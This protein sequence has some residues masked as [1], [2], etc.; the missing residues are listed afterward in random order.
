MFCIAQPKL[1]LSH[2]YSQNSFRY[3][4]PFHRLRASFM[5]IDQLTLRL[6]IHLSLWVAAIIR[7]IMLIR[8]G[9][10]WNQKTT[11]IYL[12]QKTG[13]ARKNTLMYA[14]IASGIKIAVLILWYEYFSFCRVNPDP[15]TEYWMISEIWEQLD[16][17]E[18]WQ[19]IEQIKPSICW[20]L[21]LCS[22]RKNGLKI[23]DE[24]DNLIQTQHVVS[25]SW[26]WLP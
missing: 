17:Y 22:H 3:R 5:V 1:T 25:K 16:L 12:V 13:H 4:A 9:I 15:G 26:I 20:P 21:I 11:H 19:Y 2:W 24:P 6:H 18:V 7:I 14:K 23:S 10:F 8:K